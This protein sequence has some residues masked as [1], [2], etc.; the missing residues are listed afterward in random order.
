MK[1]EVVDVRGTTVWIGNFTPGSPSVSRLIRMNGD[2]LEQTTVLEMDKLFDLQHVFARPSGIWLSHYGIGVPGGGPIAR[3]NESTG[4]VETFEVIVNGAPVSSYETLGVT[5]EG[6][7]LLL[8]V[9]SP[10]EN[11]NQD[12]Y[13]LYNPLTQTVE[14]RLVLG[15]SNSGGRAFRVL[16][17]RSGRLWIRGTGAADL[18]ENALYVY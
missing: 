2:T 14:K 7:H 3:V 6:K 15:G 8:I 17:D 9:H 5:D 4:A 16:T 12:E 13:V 1:N 10:F 11:P 18:P